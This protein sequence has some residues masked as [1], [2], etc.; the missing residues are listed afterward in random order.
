[1]R[2]LRPVQSVPVSTFATLARALPLLLPLALVA[3]MT[4]STPA[5]AAESDA[6]GEDEKNYDFG[7]RVK[8]ELRMENGDIVKHRGEIRSFGNMWTF[9]FDGADHH[10]VV[11]LDVEGA[12][13]DKSFEVTLS[14][15][16]DG[17]DVIA[18]YTDTYLVRKRQSLWTTDG[19]LAIA[20]TF[21]PTKFE[22]EDTS[23]K[24]EL[25]PDDGDD[26]LGP[27]LFK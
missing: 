13:G 10:H 6:A 1:M 16:R 22:H 14:Y 18:P 27:S 11:T 23:R 15:N 26:P 3:P 8:I 9:E 7:A 24:D 4:V 12:E 5:A 19:K 20:L 17:M 25:K 21:I 2:C